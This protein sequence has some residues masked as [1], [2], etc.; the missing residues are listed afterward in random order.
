MGA[1]NVVA[2]LVV[3]NGRILICQRRGGPFASKWE[4]PGGKVEPGEAFEAALFR[5][6]K[7]ELDIE[8]SSAKKIFRHGHRYDDGREID[9]TF[10][11]VDEYTGVLRNR[12]FEDIRWAEPK[13]LPQFDFLEGDLPL[14]GRIATEGMPD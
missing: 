14:I 9:L 7:E 4:F 11:R 6:L 3:Q 12:I 10:F 5:E 8:V 13:N 1:I 2:A